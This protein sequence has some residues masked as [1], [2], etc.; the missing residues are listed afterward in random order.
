MLCGEVEL[1]HSGGDRCGR[2]LSVIGKHVI[3]QYSK[4]A[5]CSSLVHTQA[6]TQ[7]DYMLSSH[8]ISLALG[9]DRDP[10]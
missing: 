9:N 8:G 5:M 1:E 10:R 6:Q 3:A 2:R 7:L 4:Q